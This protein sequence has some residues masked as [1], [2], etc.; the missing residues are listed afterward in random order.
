MHVSKVVSRQGG[1]EYVSYLL[2]QSYRDGGAVK[3]R[4]L[5]NLSA[6]PPAGI[7]ALRQVLAGEILVS[8]GEAL[9]I[10][11]SWPHG[12]V[13]AVLGTARKLGLEALLD[14]QP[15][16]ERNLVLAMIVARILRPASKLA[17]TRLLPTTSLGSSLG[18]EGATEDELYTAMDWLLD[19][20]SRT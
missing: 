7:E 4:T 3:T 16:R 12:H 5:A 17:T 18:V 15:S 6:L 8:A 9:T 11:R 19:R 20:T 10:E 2:R 14:P 13:A 1:R